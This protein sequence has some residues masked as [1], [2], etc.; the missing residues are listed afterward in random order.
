MPRQVIVFDLDDTLYLERDFVLSGLRAAGHWFG[1]KTGIDGLEQRCVLL[2]EQG[3]RNHLFDLAL[4]QLGWHDEAMVAKLVQT[5]RM[6]VPNIALAPDARQYLERRRNVHKAIITDGLVATQ[7]AKLA[8]LGIDRLV[9]YVVCTDVWGRAYWKPHGR[10][11]EAVEERFGVRSTSLVYVAD[12]P[13][14][15]FVTPG[16]RGWVT[17]QIERPERVHHVSAP[18]PSYEARATIRS[19]DELD[20]CLARLDADWASLLRG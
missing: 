17:V 15:D 12:N 9:D 4:T 19:L 2:F 5:Y 1:A 3:V 11:F 13:T 18:A 14:K 16:A 10:A 7:T 6:H 8:A 20:A